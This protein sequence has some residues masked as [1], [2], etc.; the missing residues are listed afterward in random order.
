MHRPDAWGYLVFGDDTEET[1]KFEMQKDPTWPLR[2]AAMNLYY[3]QRA[4]QEAKEKYASNVSELLQNLN[5]AIVDPFDVDIKADVNG[6]KAS[7][8]G[9]GQVVSVNQDRLIKVEDAGLASV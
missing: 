3:A 2:L 7:V 9:N 4:H 8:T 6:Y 5:I 1:T